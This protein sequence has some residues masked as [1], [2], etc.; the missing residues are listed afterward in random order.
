MLL[1]ASLAGFAA[2]E[3]EGGEGGVLPDPSQSPVLITH[4]HELNFGT[5]H[6]TLALTIQNIDLNSVT[7][8]ISSVDGWLTIEPDEAELLPLETITL[9]VTV[10]RGPLVTGSH[11]TCF[12]VLA[13]ESLQIRVDVQVDKPVTQPLIVP[14]LEALTADADEINH[15]AAGL[16]IWRRVTDTAVVSTS[17]EK[18]YLYP[19]LAALVPDMDIIPGL[20]TSCRLGYTGFDSLEGWMLLSADVAEVAAA[21]GESFV[22][23]ENELAL[24]AYLNGECEIDFEQLR[25]GLSYLP[26]DV[27]IIWYPSLAW[28]T[29]SAVH[30]SRALCEVVEE[31]LSCR[32]VDHSYAGPPTS[33]E[34]LMELFRAMLESLASQPPLPIIYFGCWNYCYWEYDQVH[35]I[36]EALEGRP[37]ALFYPGSARWIE[38]AEEIAN[39]LS[40]NPGG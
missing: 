7:Y 15:A 21:A 13:R 37:D 6:Q 2:G 9:E 10:D 27:K 3:E 16:Q 35:Q 36:M 25:T 30:R 33:S 23:L 28:G 8:T 40:Q 34:P 14:W 1:V 18:A 32:F 4:V 22:L 20:T 38:A 24:R 19:Q 11:V 12:G 5:D 39:L 31:E 26:P 17:P 29:P